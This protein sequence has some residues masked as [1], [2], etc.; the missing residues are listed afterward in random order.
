MKYTVTCECCGAEVDE[1]EI[2]VCPVCEQLVCDH[3]YD[4]E[5]CYDCRDN[6]NKHHGFD[7]I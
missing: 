1:D 6:F 4:G 7:L 2:Y 5:M 3:C